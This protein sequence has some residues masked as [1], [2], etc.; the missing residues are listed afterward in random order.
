M[1]LARY[2]GIRSTTE[3]SIIED[4]TTP[5]CT[6]RRAVAHIFPY[7]PTFGPFLG[8]PSNHLSGL[9]LFASLPQ[10]VLSLQRPD[11]HFSDKAQ[12]IH[13]QLRNGSTVSNDL[14]LSDLPVTRPSEQLSPPSGHGPWHNSWRFR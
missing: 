5:W 14:Q 13:K 2:A 7:I 4:Q 1:R 10:I 3:V 12:L 6:K 11:Q 8:C 9:N